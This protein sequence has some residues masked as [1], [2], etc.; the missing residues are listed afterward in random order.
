MI[1]QWV[2]SAER[3]SHGN[4]KERASVLKSMNTHLGKSEWMVGESASLADVML[5]G[6]VTQA[7]ESG[8]APANVKKWYQR[9]CDMEVFRFVVDML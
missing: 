7:K 2:E 5:W 4:N 3:F 9:C 6:A 8:K 1:D